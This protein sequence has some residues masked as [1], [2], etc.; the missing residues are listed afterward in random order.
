MSEQPAAATNFSEAVLANQQ[1]L[2]ARLGSRY[3]FV[4]CGAGSS[5]SVVAARLAQNPDVNVLLLEAGGD[6]N[7]DSVTQASLW[8]TNIGSERDWNFQGLPNSHINGRSL[9]F[10]MGKVL[11]GGSSINVMIWARGHR[12]D[13]DLFATETGNP[14]WGYDAVLRTYRQIEDWHGVP[15]PDYRGI[16]G[17]VFV[18]PVAEPQPLARATLQSASLMDIPTFENPN[19][20]MMEGPAGAAITDVRCRE[21]KR[22]SVFRSYTYPLMDR[23]NLTVLTG[24]YVRRLICDSKAVTAVEFSH[25]GRIRRA[26]V[27]HEVVLSL[28]AINTPRV[29]MHSGIGEPSELSRV[30]I[31][32]R[33]ALPGV[34]HNFQDHVGFDCVWE[35]PTPIPPRTIAEA[36]VCAPAKSGSD[37]PDFFICQAGFALSTPEVIATFGLPAA[38]WTLRG[39]LSHPQS[40][41]RLRLTGPDP[42]D[43][44]EIDANTLA[45][46]ADLTAA[47]EC[48]ELCREIGNAGPLREYAEREWIPGPLTGPELEKFVRD[49]ASTYWHEA[50]TAK[51]G[52]DDMSV[53]DGWLKVHGIDKL[54]IA[55][56]SVMPRIT[57]ANTMAPCV[58][59]GERAAEFLIAE[60][61]L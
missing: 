44:I 58:I 24:A 38:G 18:Q 15:D 25:Q 27:D 26:A 48:I 61:G 32:L 41:G 51:M 47:K 42:C 35:S 36:V 9:P 13:W 43:P 29:L 14:A 22:Q 50:G 11:G 59:I 1:I 46:S 33:H 54:R 52:R 31:P 4:V 3:D 30:G 40:R 6:D 56:G 60:H 19:G 39:A 45:D 20:R 17:R 8:P 7:V 34:G 23:P 5:G 21:D 16:G 57:T 37:A 55:D 10:S 49:S 28:G 12:G 2:A 53:V